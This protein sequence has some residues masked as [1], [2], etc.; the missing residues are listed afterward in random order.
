MPCASLGAKS[1]QA[2]HWALW[3]ALLAIGLCLSSSARASSDDDAALDVLATADYDWP[4]LT[5]LEP[6]ALAGAVGRARREGDLLTVVPDSG[7]PLTLRDDNSK[8]EDPD[9]SEETCRGFQFGGYFRS[10]QAFLV[11]IG[12]FEGRDWLLIDAESGHEAKLRSAPI[13]EPLGYRFVMI[14]DSDAYGIPGVQVWRRS[15][16]TATLEWDYVI[17]RDL[18]RKTRL[19]RWSGDRIEFEFFTPEQYR[20]SEEQRWP[21]VLR[22]VQGAWILDEARPKSP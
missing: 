22:Y 19:L 15:G 5:A 16:G 2:D 20:G 14:D 7:A 8:C 11:Y 10:R 12:Y 1:Q 9:W 17:D 6:G 18:P 13:F 4:R 3:I 21:A